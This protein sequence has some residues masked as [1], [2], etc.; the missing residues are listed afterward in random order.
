MIS[1]ASKIRSYDERDN[2][3]NQA[4]VR[5]R[6]A[7]GLVRYNIFPQI[8]CFIHEDGIFNTSIHRF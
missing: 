6:T 7:Y 4:Y 5:V 2:Y 8:I 3:M 1:Y